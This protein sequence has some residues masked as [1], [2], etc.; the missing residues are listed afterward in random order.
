MTTNIDKTNIS[1]YNLV[2]GVS[3]VRNDVYDINND[4]VQDYYFK[5]SNGG[6]I[7][8]SEMNSLTTIGFNSF[9]AN[10]YYVL[11]AQVNLL[12]TTLNTLQTQLSSLSQ[13]TLAMIKC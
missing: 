8:S 4:L 12:Q 11:K 2:K 3:I 7:R 13:I 9:L 5:D 10:E 6:D 1:Y